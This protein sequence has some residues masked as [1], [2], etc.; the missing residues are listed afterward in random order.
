MEDESITI[1]APPSVFQN[2][3]SQDMLG[4]LYVVFQPACRGMLTIFVTRRPQPSIST[5][6]NAYSN[7]WL[8]S[9][10]KY[11]VAFSDEE[12]PAGMSS[13]EINVLKTVGLKLTALWKVGQMEPLHVLGIDIDIIKSGIE[14]LKVREEYASE[15]L[16]KTIHHSRVEVKSK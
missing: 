6:Q 1:I 13:Y 11:G 12:H 5:E 16:E 9:S 8:D 2:P 15:M 10:Y 4:G 14:L 3:K 7:M